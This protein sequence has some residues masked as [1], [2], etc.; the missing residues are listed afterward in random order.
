MKSIANLKFHLMIV[1]CLIAGSLPISLPVQPAS[2]N[3]ALPLQYPLLDAPKQIQCMSGASHDNQIWWNDLGHNSRDTL[4]RLPGGPVTTDT[5]VT[6]RF[7]S[8]CNDLTAVRARVWN[9]RMDSQTIFN[10]TLTVSDEA[11]D[12]WEVTLPASPDPTVYWYRFIAIDGT[13][14]DYYEDDSARTGGW[15]N[16]S[17]ESTDNSWQLTIYDPS[18]QTPD[19]VKNG[20]V[21]QI[22]PDRF[23]D[24]DV[25]NDTPA[26]SFFYDTDGTIYRSNS[27][28]WNQVVCD[29]RDPNGDCPQI[30]SQNFYGGDMQGLINQLEY[31]DELGITA[32]YLN[33]IFESPSNH[34]YDTTDYTVIDDNFGD[35]TLFE[36]LVAQAN[37]LGINVILDGVFNHTSSDSIYFDRYSRYS[38]IGACEDPNSPYR[39]WYYFQDVTPGSG[40]CVGSDGTPNAA[41][42]SSWFGYDSL[43]KLNS[44]NPDVRQLIWDNE[45]DS[46]APYWVSSGRADGW[47]L[48]VG[49]DVDPGTLNDP[50]NNYWEGFRS[51]VRAANPQ[52]YITGEEWG[53]GSSW[54]LGSEWDGV[55]N[56]QFSSAALGFWR[57]EPFLDNDHNSGSSAGVL[58]P[59]T[60]TQLDE[61]L[62]NLQE[63]YPP[64][65]FFA[66]LNLLDSHDT[67]RALFMLDHNT[68]N[69]DDDLYQ[70]PDYQWDDAITR[71]KGVVILQMTL[72]GAPTIYYGD[73]VGLVGPVTYDDTYDVWQDDPYNRQPYPWLDESGIPFY[74]HLKTAAGQDQLLDHYTLLTTA[75]NAHPALRIGSFDTLLTDDTSKVYAYGRRL[76][77]PQDAAI[78]VINRDDTNH[79]ISLNVT[80]YLPAGAVFS[81]ILNN[82]AQYTVQTDGSLQIQVQGMFGAVLVLQSGDL[83][84]PDAP[85]NLAAIE[86]EGQVNLTWDATGDTVRYNLYRSMFSGGGFNLLTN[87]YTTSYTDTTVLNGVT[88]YYVVSSIDSDGLESG[89]SNEASAMPHFDIDDAHLQWPEEITH[90]IGLTPTEYI[91]G[92]ILIEDLTNLPG[93][94]PGLLAQVGFGPT[95]TLPTDWIWW[96][97]AIYNIDNPNGW[98]EW[99]G[100]LLP[101]FIGDF[102]Y[103]YRFSTTNGRDWVYADLGGIFTG[104]PPNPGL[105]HVLPS[106][107]TLPPDTPENLTLSNWSIDFLELSW[108]PVQADPTL[109]AYDL[110]R[111]EISNTVGTKIARIPS[112]TTTFTDTSVTSGTTYYYIVQAVDTSFNRSGY[113]NQASGVPEAKIVEVTFNVTVPSFT[114]DTVYI[115]GN[116]PELGNWDPGAIPMT[117]GVSNTWTITRT[118]LDDQQLQFKFA[119]GN[120]DTVEKGPDGNEELAN[121]E[122]TVDYGIDGQQIVN[123]AV[124]NWR[125][126]IV[127][128]FS[129]PTHATNVPTDTLITVTWSQRMNLAVNFVVNL[130][131]GPINGDFIYNDATMTVTF[132]PDQPLE[133]ETIY[134]VSVQDQVDIAG[135][136]QKVPQSWLFQTA[137]DL[138]FV[139]FTSEAYTINEAAGTLI[140]TVTLSSP[141]LDTVTVDY[142]TTDGNAIAG[143]D[144]IFTAGTL[145]FQPQQ[146]ERT[147]TLA[148]LDDGN[149]ESNETFDIE[150]SN[151]ENASLGQLSSLLITI[152]D[153]D[154]PDFYSLSLPVLYKP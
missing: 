66:M 15:G 12:W 60:P 132:T 33:P 97:D 150:L 112:P 76:L 130:P 28:D 37:N 24:G 17:D 137:G 42:Y 64:Q 53:Y 65:A 34:K 79:A 10:L 43:P 13:D 26:G 68:D 123:L 61:R 47:R 46:I 148:I 62:K 30:W 103:V 135:D 125:D 38:N 144:Y 149:D 70:N 140:L 25:S 9:D 50:N 75:R 85:N 59:L 73:E 117:E 39:D 124:A 22:F 147:I 57:D 118:F 136:I 91:Y 29:P 14:I 126:P 116:Q 54:L 87:T 27:S 19:W 83:T 105:I 143:E 121:R 133:P 18:F 78:V 93:A 86:G 114:P 35:L 20:I 92:Q 127:T 110:F 104:S 134:S 115:V 56:Y 21:Y 63:R 11:Y 55:M 45:G 16:P 141:T 111:S 142:T 44:S 113:S 122:L 1:I 81:D 41:T 154:G 139:Q 153:N 94:A 8:T 72:P 5:P 100:N 71:L 31:L 58:D 84:P 82:N 131:A 4:Y 101:E 151:P 120:W 96:V 146:M 99:M 119:R 108:E 80:G 67:N 109:Y 2:A 77:N 107:D 23:R 128:S 102:H 95:D 36:S 7:R 89:N 69:N 32:I 129:P 74:S 48:D 88:Y 98:D 3:S 138:P 49:G 6:L 51:A 52:G 40:P 90:T 152:A 145:T 106:E